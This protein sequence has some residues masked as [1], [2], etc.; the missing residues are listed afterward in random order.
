MYLKRRRPAAQND[1]IEPT[2][3]SFYRGQVF[4]L[5]F[6]E[7]AETIFDRTLKH[8]GWIYILAGQ[9][10]SRTGVEREDRRAA[11]FI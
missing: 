9:G 10:A 5:H 3:P 1:F 8:A 11:P 2:N 6:L 7:R 4:I